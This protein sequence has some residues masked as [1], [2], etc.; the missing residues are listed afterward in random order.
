MIVL[1]GDVGNPDGHYHLGDEAMLES[2]V[3]ALRER[4]QHEITVISSDP[5]S[6]Q[7]RYGVASIGRIGFTGL[8]SAQRESRLEAVVGAARGELGRIDWHDSAWAVIEAIAASTGVIVTGG[9]NLSLLW[10]EHVY[11]RVAL[12]R[13]ATVMGRPIA[14]SGQMLGPFLDQRTGELV[15]ELLASAVAIGVRDGHSLEIAHR[16]IGERPVS[17][18][19]DDALLLGDDAA[20][21]DADGVDAGPVVATFAPYLAGIPIDAFVAGAA[22]TLET[23]R[24]LTGADVQFVPHAGTLGRHDDDDS[25]LH[26]RVAERLGHGTLSPLLDATAT[27]TLHRSASFT[28]STR[29]HPLVF[30]SL[31]GRPMIGAPADDYTAT[32]ISGA[33]A[34]IGAQQALVPAGALG[35]SACIAAAT[36]VWAARDLIAAAA[37]ARRPGLIDAHRRW[38]DALADS[39]GAAPAV[40]VPAAAELALV[41]E[42]TRTELTRI[43]S[44]HLSAGS[45]TTMNNFEATERGL[46]VDAVR[47]ELDEATQTI[48]DL[49]DELARSTQQASELEGAL[50]QSHRLLSELAD[51]ALQRGLSRNV[52][53][54]IPPSTIE[55]L[56]DT[57]TFRWARR[58]RSAWAR[59]RRS[60]RRS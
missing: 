60:A 59:V 44:V 12:A 28:L 36:S 7:E 4:G 34:V 57:R 55:A 10:P 43:T 42:P 48:A 45:R 40:V 53:R 5:A 2:A 8:T 37:A 24:Q 13:I 41:D 56:L 23:L 22:T 49:H 20:G 29:Y 6:T 9:G 54:Y 46:E 51:P 33:L 19:G 3:H 27:A 17:L 31:A 16:L 39:F 50:A 11:E 14:L 58:V 21:L 25:V 15:G 47:T 30:A 35:G 52:D 18:L 26:A 38:W 32:K 1:I